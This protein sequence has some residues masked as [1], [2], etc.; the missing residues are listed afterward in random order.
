MCNMHGLISWKVKSYV[1]FPFVHWLHQ[2][3]QTDFIWYFKNPVLRCMDW[4]DFSRAIFY[5]PILKESAGLPSGLFSTHFLEIWLF[6]VFCI[7][8]LL[9]FV[10]LVFQYFL[11]Q[12]FQDFVLSYIQ[13]ICWL[14][15]WFIL[16]ALSWIG[17]AIKLEN[18]NSGLT[19]IRFWAVQ[20]ASSSAVYFTPIKHPHSAEFQTRIASRLYDKVLYEFKKA[21]HPNKKIITRSIMPVTSPNSPPITLTHPKSRFDSFWDPTHLPIMFKTAFM[22]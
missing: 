3:Y 8:L 16:S 14:A 12:D 7:S 11:F 1:G 19:D 15:I 9:Y 4:F 22:C 6:S 18:F 2:F 10:Y 21:C 20:D 13:R 5:Y 17:K